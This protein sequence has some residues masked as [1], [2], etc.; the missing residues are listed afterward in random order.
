MTPA[1]PVLTPVPYLEPGNQ[2]DASYWNT[3]F[4]A[5]D[6]KLTLILASHSLLWWNLA[7]NGF[8]NLWPGYNG[9]C[10][11]FGDPNLVT[12]IVFGAYAD[13]FQYSHQ[14][15][16]NYVA[17]ILPPDKHDDNV[18]LLT[19]NASVTPATWYPQI[20]VKAGQSTVATAAILD[21][22][23]QAHTVQYTPNAGTIPPST[24]KILDNLQINP[25]HVRLYDVAEL[26]CTASTVIPDLWNKYNFFR[27][28]NF[29]Q[30]AIAVT[31]N[32]YVANVPA[33]GSQCVRRSGVGATYTPGWNHFFPMMA[34]DP[35]TFW[36][37][38]SAYA[39]QS[40]TNIASNNCI[41]PSIVAQIFGAML[42]RNDGGIRGGVVG[43]QTDNLTN[44]GGVITDMDWSVAW[45][46]SNIYCGTGKP[47]G[48]IDP[49]T[50]IG[51]L[52]VQK[53]ALLS[54][55][56]PSGMV[57][58][59]QGASPGTQ[60]FRYPITFNGFET[61]ISDF[62]A[63]GITVVQNP[64]G[65]FTLTSI[66]AG[67]L[68]RAHDVL[69][70]S[71]N[72]NWTF[73]GQLDLG[74][75]INIQGN[76]VSTLTPTGGVTTNDELVLR[77]LPTQSQLLAPRMGVNAV[78]TGQTSTVNLSSTVVGVPNPPPVSFSYTSMALNFGQ[79]NEYPT[80][81]PPANTLQTVQTLKNLGITTATPNSKFTAFG[82]IV[83]WDVQVTVTGSDNF[84][85]EASWLFN[86]LQASMRPMIWMQ[87]AFPNPTSGNVSGNLQRS[88]ANIGL[89][90]GIS[91]VTPLIPS[92]SPFPGGR[93]F[94]DWTYLAETNAL[95]D[96]VVKT[97]ANSTEL[98][99]CNIVRAFSLQGL[100]HI[101][102][103]YAAKAAILLARSWN[104]AKEQDGPGPLPSGYNA[105]WPQIRQSL[106][107]NDLTWD[108]YPSGGG[109]AAG[110]AVFE[111]MPICVEHYNA[112]AS[113]VNCAN[114]YIPLNQA[115]IFEGIASY[116]IDL[117]TAG[118]ALFDAQGNQ[119]YLV[120]P[121][122][123]YMAWNGSG[124]GEGE[125]LM[126][127]GITPL[128]ALPSYPAS[129]TG[130]PNFKW[131]DI[132]T[133]QSFATSWGFTLA[134]AGVFVPC[135]IIPT[136]TS[137]TILPPFYAGVGAAVPTFLAQY[138]EGGSWAK[139]VSLGGVQTPYSYQLQ[140]IYE[141]GYGGG[142]TFEGGVGFRGTSGTA[143]LVQ[144]SYWQLNVELNPFQ[145]F[146]Y[147]ITAATGVSVA[148]G[149]ATS[150][151]LSD[152]VVI[153]LPP[154]QPGA[155]NIL[156]YPDLSMAF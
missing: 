38:N 84:S 31:F 138:A 97:I 120:W 105:Q 106:L 85:G 107:T 95:T 139:G 25:E 127:L 22:S 39:I 135:E 27:I 37:A 152:D 53:G 73:G 1:P 155:A 24:Y 149:Q 76:G 2:L 122:D 61:I 98:P 143:I 32:G 137:S 150:Q 62:A 23:M 14:P 28:H 26:V 40:G 36:P 79:G 63:G 16:L 60:A 67:S 146:V 7:S 124:S 52:L 30:K 64:D 82:L 87:P 44:G 89:Y 49:G 92:Q 54:I 21:F 134:F 151:T 83:W 68:T 3:L 140:W 41:N 104:F 109:I 113:Y 99:K 74:H 112:I 129:L 33:F 51:D 78:I 46:A 145:S 136:T 126:A 12:D 156:I 65:T 118:G 144:S 56:M 91:D 17:A 69:D 48:A 114:R 71:S 81:F 142:L 121:R 94:P 66:L 34:G 103:F 141:A 57:N 45:D 10:F 42:N 130:N 154:K 86:G 43:V 8:R 18:K 115:S 108:S 75:D 70:V 153:A 11:F 58:N 80:G 128:T 15:F 9:K 90:R 116:N 55:Q 20:G 102:A 125:G 147:I 13:Y 6:A 72:F 96:S 110:P 88:P 29:S 77:P 101:T 133:V 119:P 148:T 35:R 93:Y 117:N 19:P 100:F 4:Q 131:I 47:F 5:A 123:A 50:L 111:R 59:R 132:D